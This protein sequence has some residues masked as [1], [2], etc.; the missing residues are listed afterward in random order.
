VGATSALVAIVQFLVAYGHYQET[1][2][3]GDNPEVLARIKG[4]MS[5]WITFSVGEMLVWCAA[6]PLLVVLTR[7]WLLPVVVIGAGLVLS[8]TRGVWI[9]SAAA[10]MSIALTL[11]RKVLAAVLVPVAVVALIAAGPIVH[12]ISM[13]FQGN[14]MPDENRVAL[15]QA[16]VGM[17]HDHPFFGVGPERVQKEFDQ[18]YAGPIDKSKLY[19]G[20]ME[21][22]F[23]QIAAERG[24]ITLAAF[25]W[26]MVELFRGAFRLR[27]DPDKMV[28]AAGLSSLAVLVGFLV[29]GLFSYPFGDS[30]TMMLFLFLMSIPFG[31]TQGEKQAKAATQPRS[32]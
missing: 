25:I 1:R 8:F 22:N 23:M 29:A 10:F 15:L 12:R 2:Q 9:G 28:R 17:V 31:L 6:I 14:F 13:S 11:P 18:Y 27:R 32:A 24:L 4:F 21:N 19:T 7:K 16:G 20:H 3:L 30:E 5:H 26:L